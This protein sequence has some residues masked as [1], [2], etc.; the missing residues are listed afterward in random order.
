MMR[1]PFAWVDVF[2]DEP[3]TGNPVA[4]VPDADALP[5]ETMRRVA[6]EFNQ[7]ET[8]FVLEPS[9]PGATRRLR[10]FT[11]I[12][13]EVYGAGHNTL[14]AWWLL[15]AT[16]RVEVG[17]AGA[18]LSQEVGDEVLPLR[19]D[20]A[21]GRPAAIRQ[22]QR[23]ARFLG[24]PGDLPGLA[25]ALGL[26][27]GDLDAGLP[28]QVVGTGADHLMV[29]V[30]GRA[31]VDRAEPDA[32]RLRRLLEAAGGEGCYVFSLDPTLPGSTAYARFFNPTVGIPED[33]ATGTAAGPLAAYLI[34]NGR[35][36]AGKP[37][38]VEQGHALGR[39]SLITVR[40]DG[41]AMEIAG[42]CVIVAEGVL[43]L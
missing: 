32:P 39:P 9:A 22:T 19:V 30:T 15:V 1:V 41:P 42:A 29:P 14:G 37:V 34:E 3:L 8:T 4:V 26:A 18:T 43:H 12:G 25:A 17:P 35:A 21:D 11:P 13:A 20:M 10:S 40:T 23:P 38:L 31:A 7:S 33:P 16:G 28:V 6:R 5:E 36:G 2:A 27:P 24:R